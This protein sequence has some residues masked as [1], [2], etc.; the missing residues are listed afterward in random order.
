MRNKYI[1][2]TLEGEVIVKVG[3]VYRLLKWAGTRSR[4]VFVCLT[5]ELGFYSIANWKP[6]I[7]SGMTVGLHSNNEL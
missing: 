5:K 4:R 6:L 1:L 7:S 3:C 2:V